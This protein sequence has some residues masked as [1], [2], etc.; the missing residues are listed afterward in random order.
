M[1][2]KLMIVEDEPV[3]AGTV[4][5]LLGQER[6]AIVTAADGRQA[7]AMIAREKPDIILSDLVMPGMDGMQLLDWVREKGY[8][9]AFILM[10]VKDSA[11]GPIS[12]GRHVP[13]FCLTKPFD[14]KS[15]LDAVTE[16]EAGKVA[17][18]NAGGEGQGPETNGKTGRSGRHERK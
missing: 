8:D 11:F 12:R 2:R 3:L 4:A 14:R 13:D 10:T 1:K 7:T 18:G 15:L 17:G 16:A 9:C 5:A 6:Y